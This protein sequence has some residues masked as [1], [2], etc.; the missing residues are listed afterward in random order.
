MRY[1]MVIDLN[2]CVRCRSCY[3]NC[4]AANQIP[5]Q[6]D[7]PGKP[8]RMW[9]D[10]H[11]K[12]KYPAVAMVFIPYHCM[13]CDAAPCVGVC[14]TGANHKNS[15][16]VVTIDAK[17][18]IGCKACVKACPYGA[19]YFREDRKVAD[20]CDFCSA[21]VAKGLAPSCADKC[22][23]GAI[24]FGDLD[25]P[26]SE[27]SIKIASAGA[28]PLKAKMAATKPKVYYVSGV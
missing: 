19:S 15:S 7:V 18:C 8:A 26:R 20:K 10:E 17:K 11:P 22:T 12:G 6:F 2:D 25:D 9:F 13:Q 5:T 27:V 24:L 16:G 1:G 14:P 28:K 23:G 4:K 3:V 21:R